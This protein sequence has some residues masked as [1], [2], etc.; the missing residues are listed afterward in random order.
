MAARADHAGGSLPG[1]ED[2]LL[3]GKGNGGRRSPP[4][5]KL[6]AVAAV[7]DAKDDGAFAC[8]QRHALG[9]LLLV[10]VSVIWTGASMLVQ[11]IMVTLK[12]ER[13]FFLTYV[14]NGLFSILLLMELCRARLGASGAAKWLVHPGD[15]SWRQEGRAAM[16]VSVV[17]FAAQETYNASLGGTTVSVSTI[18]SATSSVFTLFQSF[19][20]L[21]EPFSWAVALGVAVW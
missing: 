2:G 12:F 9:A 8:S 11:Y 17:W 1:E 6:A 15:A 20:F 18:L 10:V 19:L 7:D 3:S 16:F 5:A 4:A 21:R 13:P 14:S